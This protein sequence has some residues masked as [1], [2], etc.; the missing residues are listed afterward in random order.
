MIARATVAM[1]LVALLAAPALAAP[2]DV[3]NDVASTI[4]SPFCKGVTL[5]DC[6]SAAAADLR[7]RIEAWADQGWSKDRII[8]E[9]ESE[10]GSRIRATPETSGWGL[11]AWLLPL[12]ILGLGLVTA[13]VLA[14]RWITRPRP[15]S[16]AITSHDHHRIEGE[17]AALREPQ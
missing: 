4:M 12:A 14:R 10:Y 5:H 13:W 8:D 6:P 3:A 1:F 9:L 16:A 2:E 7:E 17:L 11:I 15:E